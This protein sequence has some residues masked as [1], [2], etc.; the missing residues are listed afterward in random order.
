M[1]GDFSALTDQSTVKLDLNDETV[2]YEITIPT[3]SYRMGVPDM[4]FG[5]A[6]VGKYTCFRD[7]CKK[8]LYFHMNVIA[9]RE[10]LRLKNL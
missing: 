3:C 9:S 1:S 2:L 5:T 6:V 10:F 4:G 8:L 7:G